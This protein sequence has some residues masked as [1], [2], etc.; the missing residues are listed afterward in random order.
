[1]S[2]HEI[3]FT[4]S[5]KVVK[6]N[7]GDSII[8]SSNSQGMDLPFSCMQGMCTTCIAKL[9]EGEIE[10]LEPPE[11]NTL[12]EEDIDNNMVLLCVATPKSSLIIEES[13]E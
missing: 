11:A 7:E 3:K 10:Y 6:V 12:T 2:I 8:S 9:V 4:R 5:N 1:M 13:E